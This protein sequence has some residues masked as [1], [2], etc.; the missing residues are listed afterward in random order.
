[1][2]SIKNHRLHYNNNP[3]AY[4]RTPNSSGTIEPDWLVMHYTA[5]GNYTSVIRW[6]TNSQARASAHLVIGYDGAV[7]QLAPF[8]IKT[9]HAG[10]SFWKGKSGLNSNTIGI[11][12]VNKGYAVAAEDESIRAKHRNGG[13]TRNWQVYPEAQL[14]VALEIAVTLRDKYELTEVVGHDDISPGRKSDPGPA[15]DMRHFRGRMFGRESDDSPFDLDI[16]EGT[17]IVDTGGI[18]DPLNM[19]LW[20]RLESAIVEKIPDGTKV[21]LIRKNPGQHSH[22]SEIFY[23]NQIG[24]VVTRYLV[25]G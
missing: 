7:T 8:N 12:L 15:F 23:N 24:W 17:A 13:P 16:S 6:L 22:W 20:P 1:M 4:E 14:E 10:Q 18:D 9:W 5:S 25:D 2:Y 3:V 19:R 21:I 11:E